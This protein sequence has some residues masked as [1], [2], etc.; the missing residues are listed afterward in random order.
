MR[1]LI[2]TGSPLDPGFLRVSVPALVVTAALFC[3]AG[4]AEAQT[5]QI[6]CSITEN[7]GPGRGTIVVEQDGREVGGGSCG[8]ALSVPVGKCK[9]TVRLDGTLNNPSKR[10]TVQVSAGKSTPVSVDFQTGVLEVRIETKRQSGTGIVTVNR[11]SERIGTLG[12][13]VAARLSTGSYEVVVRLGGEER[14][15]AVDL[16]P[17]Q[18]RLIRAQF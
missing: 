9:V 13:G 1:I 12:S 4:V 2:Q 15:Y 14:R 5:G 3:G 17:G 10:V 7:G 11:G 16:R 18:R 8:A 6:R